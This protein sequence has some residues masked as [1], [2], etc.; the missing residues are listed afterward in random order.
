M[1]GIPFTVKRE[2]IIAFFRDYEIFPNH[3]KIG[4]NSEH[5]RTGEAAVLFPDEKECKR[6][7]LNK[8]GQNIS[9]RWIELY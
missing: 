6:A 9:H 3:I 2:D 8:Q 5:T 1:K 4:E 7:F